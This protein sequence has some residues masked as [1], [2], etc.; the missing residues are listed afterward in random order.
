MYTDATKSSFGELPRAVFFSAKEKQ[1]PDKCLYY[2]AKFRQEQLNIRVPLCVVEA[3]NGNVSATAKV[4]QAA[5][6]A[7][8]A[9]KCQFMFGIKNPLVPVIITS[10]YNVE[11]WLA[12]HT[13]DVEKKFHL[14][15]VSS[16]LRTHSSVDKP[17]VDRLFS[18]FA[19]LLVNTSKVLKSNVRKTKRRSIRQRILENIRSLQPLE[20]VPESAE[21]VPCDRYVPPPEDSEQDSSEGE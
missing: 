6:Y 1:E 8:T 18:Q 21:P 10:G 12:W 5:Y 13:F 11:G 9:I 19:A 16:P 17:R 20:T 4:M 15:Q 3:A 7:G 2:D 14:A